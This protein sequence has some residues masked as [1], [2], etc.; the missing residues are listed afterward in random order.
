MMAGVEMTASERSE[1][2]AEI[3]FLKLAV[4]P[5]QVRNACSEH[6]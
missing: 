1:D 3:L 2:I 5:S 4:T 6:S